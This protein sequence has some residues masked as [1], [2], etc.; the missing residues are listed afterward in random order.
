M[1]DW[2]DY[3]LILALHRAGTLRGAAIE[4]GVN[5][6]TISRK[7]AILN[8]TNG[9]QLF[10]RTTLGYQTTP[11]GDELLAI[12]EQIEVLAIATERKRRALEHSLRGKISLSIPPAIGQ[13]LILEELKDFQN[14]YP[15]I[16]LSIHSS[17]ALV[18]LDRSEADIVIRGSDNPP[19][20]LVGRKVG[21]VALNYYANKAY[22]ENTAKND[23]VWIGKSI[24]EKKPE[25]IKASPYPNKPIGIC[26][27]DI[28][29]R[30][31]LA[32]SGHG[33][34]RSACYM[35]EQEESL[36]KIGNSTNIHYSDLW[37]LTHPD[38]RNTPRIKV[39]MQ[40]LSTT[41]LGKES[42]LQ[43]RP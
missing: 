43:G 18:N 30:H 7:L 27:D 10:E 14:S 22:F 8:K 21:S 6:S 37:V 39:L 33:L 40:F 3:R 41:L 12:A 1:T 31:Q 42:L 5:H 15:D 9:T 19:E 16:Q 23:L 29:M 34:T 25:W 38:L 35:A 13:Y 28:S 11:Y 32:L 2:D 17:Y 24:S 20:H 4:L 36:M 26:S